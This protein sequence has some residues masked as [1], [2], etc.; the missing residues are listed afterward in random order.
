MAGRKRRV[1][2]I[3]GLML[4]MSISLGKC[5]R[6]DSPGTSRFLAIGPSG[7]CRVGPAPKA[8][9]FGAGRFGP[10]KLCR[11]GETM[12]E[13]SDA[14]L[15]G[16]MVLHG[17]RLEDLR[18]VLS[19]W[20][21][22]EPLRPLENEVVL[23]QSNGIAQWF[24]AALARDVTDGGMG[25]AAAI[26]VQLPG[27]FVWS[28]YRA[29]LGAGLP[30][31][32]EFD[33]ERLVWRLLRLIGAHLHKPV[34]ETLRRY[35]ADDTDL[36]KRYQLAGRIADLFDQYQVYRADWLVDWG[37]GHDLLRDDRGRPQKIPELQRWQPALWRSVLADVGGKAATLHRGALHQR[38]VDAV[39]SLPE[40]PA[41]LPRRV[42]V[43]GISSLPQQV[44]ATL[45]ALARFTQ[46]L[47]V[48]ANPCRYYW[49]DIVDQREWVAG[50]R[51]RQV[52]KPGRP[53]TLDPS[54][55]HLHS[56]SLLAAWGKHGRDYLRLLDRLDTPEHYRERFSAWGQKI[57]L[58][59]DTPGRTV[60]EQVQQGILDLTP[61]P[62][63]A[64]DKTAILRGDDSITFHVAHSAQREV[65]ILH[66]A[67]L[68]RMQA[69]ADAGTPL[70]PRDI[71]VMVPDI[72]TY[73]SA[74]R[75]VFGR[76]AASDPRHI[77]FTV[78]DQQ[79]RGS[80]PALIALERLL[81]LPDLRLGATELCDL[82]DVPALRRRFGLDD[83]ALPTLR[84]WIHEAGIRWGLD[85]T[86]R[87]SLGLPARGENTWQ[88]GLRRM[89]LGYAVGDADIGLA[90]DPY[91]EI[92]GLQAPLV[93]ILADL[94]NTLRHYWQLL[95]REA[96]P[97]EW[98]VSLHGL[99]RD[100]FDPR[101]DEELL[102]LERLQDSLDAWQE[103]T[104]AAALEQALPLAVVR[105][106]WLSA[107][108]E[109]GLS[110]RFLGGGV[111]FATLMPMRAIPFRVIALLGMNDGDYPRQR[112]PS[113][114][115]LMG[116]AR[117]YRP[118]DRSRRED[119]RYLFLE[120]LL[121]SR[122]AL[123]LSW[124]G[125]S[126]RD[127]SER[128]PSVLVG[129][130][131][132]HLVS[133]WY[134]DGHAPD[135]SDAGAQVLAAL[136]VEHPLQPFSVRYFDGSDSRL[137]TYA[138]E[139]RQAH[140]ATQHP[141]GDL[142]P[143][144]VPEAS[145]TLTTLG[146]FLRR[147]VRQFFQQR[148]KVYF[149]TPVDIADDN[150]PFA[151]DALDDHRLA[152][153]LVGAALQ[154]PD[155]A[156]GDA[157]IR[158]ESDRLRANGILPLAAFGELALAVPLQRAGGVHARFRA[159]LARWPVPQPRRELTIPCG[160]L[161][162]EDWVSDLRSDVTGETV[163]VVCLIA[164]LCD[165]SRQ[166]RYA[167]LAQAWTTHLVAHAAGLA[168]TSQLVA[169]DRSACLEPL[170][171]AVAQALLN[172]LLA[173]MRLGMRAPLP[174]ACKT[175]FAWLAAAAKGEGD[176]AVAAA[177]RYNRSSYDGS[178]GECEEDPYLA[179]SFPEFEALL[180]Q[181]FEAWLGIYRPLF[182]RLQ[183]AEVA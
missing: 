125:R 56:H 38:F 124:V 54:Q 163:R 170:P 4:R 10:R 16:L 104:A 27:R 94:V 7:R 64:T 76:H 44:L 71:M 68:A 176:A 69:A 66:D 18:D 100:F 131:R 60:L 63:V 31:H 50:E 19:L 127:N 17:N 47:V 153:H 97:A 29:V 106:S 110:Q 154:A 83:E 59:G 95:R 179:R 129:Q 70:H 96:T 135:A 33:K 182:E 159:A 158:R 22:R 28:A 48:V 12:T 99:L 120:A 108:D 75:A 109:R 1:Y 67:L 111:V 105:E 181:G 58:F 15:P 156:S 173:A 151:L 88:F 143:E 53:A 77:P 23:V 45:A 89:L 145:L 34:Y 87:E 98:A 51:R 80:S 30:E 84:R 90:I 119:D 180:R 155:E 52:I 134:C 178:R 165:R 148:L 152:A 150:E 61:S 13:P 91:A 146:A 40:R 132:D 8:L 113:D 73:A 46:V 130:L 49:A 115:D 117:L 122:E 26:D 141:A 160:D 107:L 177:L 169:P 144:W 140:S 35:L 42:T 139:W 168:F 79:S 20:L 166:P 183:W 3:A 101:E 37:A 128:P 112:Q 175:A 114:F 11:P 121:S 78:A 138:A 133:G 36:T 57:D 92:G 85:A 65:E 14:I 172:D 43:F 136:T 74:I 149:E 164:D 118:G 174:L 9:S 147:P 93:G 82:L 25:I 137:F 161:L 32:S 39:Q 55:L 41:A 2:P 142:L 21:R 103:A 171:Q 167:N 72:A 157:A 123:H 6:A 62:T 5:A 86:Q 102:E 162:I 126:V 81:S 24:K 116:D